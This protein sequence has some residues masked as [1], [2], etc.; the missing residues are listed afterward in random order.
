MPES[1]EVPQLD[2]LSMERINRILDSVVKN[3]GL[4]KKLDEGKAI[5]V[6]ERAVGRDIAEQ[7][8]PIKVQG[9][10]LF[11]EVFSSSWK[12]ELTFLKTDI[13]RKLNAMT[14]K[15]VLDDIIFVSGGG[16][17]TRDRRRI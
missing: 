3:L 16:G 7:T 5:T 11:V 1:A 9:S 14:G 10:K 8:R 15:I 13:I 17:S 12:N 2:G 4:G 6:W